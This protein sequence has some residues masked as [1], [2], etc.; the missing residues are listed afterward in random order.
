VTSR[1]PTSVS[2][3]PL[4][5]RKALPGLAAL[6]AL[7]LGC[8]SPA[9]PLGMKPDLAGRFAPEPIRSVNLTISGGQAT[10]PVGRSKIASLDFGE[11]LARALE[12]SGLLYAV[13]DRTGDYQIDVHIEELR[14]PYFAWTM[15]V[16][17]VTS[18]SV[19][20]RGER[21]PFWSDVI[22]TKYE[23]P[24][25]VELWGIKRLRLANE[26]A[27]RSNIEAAIVALRQ[28]LD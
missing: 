9:R 19:R 17:L 20:R 11:A 3:L 26:G 25:P 2:P 12:E 7:V 5:R 27:A 24:F 14:Q 28:Q 10:S 21:E 8:A 13:V 23:A 22:A 6:A 15:G 16:D 1:K 18:W 4:L